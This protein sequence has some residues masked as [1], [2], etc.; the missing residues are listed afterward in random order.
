MARV[1]VGVMTRNRLHYVRETVQSVL[2]QGDVDLRL[3][4]SEN[5]TTPQAA[6]A[7][8]QWLASLQDARVQYVQQAVDGGEYGQGRGLWACVDDEAYLCLMHDDDGMEP[9]YLAAAVAALD[10]HPEAVLFQSGQHVIDAEGRMR[11]DWSADHARLQG[12][13]RPEGLMRD[14]LD[15]LLRHGLFAVSGTVLRCSAVRQRGLV[16]DDLGGIYPFEFNVFLRAL[17]RGAPAYYTPRPLLRYRWHAQSMRQTDGAALTGYMVGDLVRLLERRRFGGRSERLRRRLLAF[18]LRNLAIIHLVAGARGSA[19]PC[20]W[21]ALRAYPLAPGLW[22]AALRLALLPRQL[23]A[24]FA[25]RV[26]LAAPSP[27]WAQA[28]PPLRAGD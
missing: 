6:E 13:R 16:D 8:Q 15:S 17:E 27:A 21:R 20:M 4:V 9:G 3:V 18:N 22:W 25:P 5:P 12:R 7:L 1:L 19:W 10:A 14:A 11:P 28:I 23:R 26:N 2:A 24:H